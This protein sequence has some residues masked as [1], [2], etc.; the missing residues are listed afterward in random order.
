[1]QAEGMTSPSS[2]PAPAQ[3][4][5]R[6][7][8][9]WWLG[10][11][12]SAF[13]SAL[14]GIATSFLVLHQTGS[15]GAM[16][17]N[18]ALAM[19]PALL[20]PFMGALVD[21][22]PLKPPLILGNVLRGLL[23]LAVGGLAL[24]G[25]IPVEVIYLASFLTGLVGAFY[26]PATAGMVARLVPADQLERA[27]GLMQG[28]TQSMTMLGFVGGGFLVAALGR[29]QA[30]LLDGATFL[31]FAVLL[32]FVTLP[33]RAPGK[34]G[35]TFWQS[36]TA[37]L[38]YVRGSAI[39]VGLPLL[40]LLLNASFAPLDMLMPKQ[41]ISVGAGERGYGLFFG[42]LLAGGVV[43]SLL[44]AA[45]GKKVNPAAASVWGLAGM[46]L[47]TL[48]LAF[49]HTPPQMYALAAVS[50][51]AN[52]LT[53][54]GIGVIFQKRVAPEYF[55][56]VGSLLGMVGMIGMPLTLLLLAPIADRIAIAAIFTIS[57]SLAMLGALAW[58][59]LLRLDNAEA[60]PNPSKAQGETV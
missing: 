46:G 30:L 10:G 32:M 37:G 26:S 16:G 58:A 24:R 7:F 1:M 50:G 43:G 33:A 45:L 36:F 53:N 19:L 9:L 13:G 20:Q 15:A 49:A 57:G 60:Q 47:A 25:S 35:E 31:L 55:G 42:V 17:I 23:Q 11:A 29:A 52:A 6:N 2:A 39:M 5:N 54:Q 8:L 59:W 12:Q 51:L 14:A 22:W 40:A 28:T 38:R 44:L 3:L 27:T 41:M 56:R 18:L 34:A 4:W 48:G 21:R